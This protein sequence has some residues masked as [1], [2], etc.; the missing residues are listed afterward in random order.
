MSYGVIRILAIMLLAVYAFIIRNKIK[1]RR[2][3]HFND[4]MDNFEKDENGLYP[5]EANTDDSPDSIPKNAKVFKEKEK[6]RR[7]RW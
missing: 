6:I 3:K 5:W 1:T 7:G 4:S 2:A